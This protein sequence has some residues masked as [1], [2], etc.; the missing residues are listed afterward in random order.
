[1]ICP[2]VTFDQISRGEA[3]KLL[4][5]WQNK[6]GACER[7]NMAGLTYALFENGQPL[8]L[9]MSATLIA[10]NVGG[11]QSHLTRDNCIELARLCAARPGLCRVALRLWR[12]FV[13]PRLGYRYAMSYQDSDLHNG[14]TYRFDGWTRLAHIRGTPDLRSGR[15]ARNKYV[16]VWELPAPSQ[17]E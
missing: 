5:Q 12:E 16:W 14:N 7:G 2:L 6:M 4:I 1:M 15:P 3:N 17:A 8:A 11:G 10:P 13:F 9:A